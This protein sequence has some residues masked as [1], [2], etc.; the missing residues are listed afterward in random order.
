MEL[1]LVLRLVVLAKERHTQSEAKVESRQR[2]RLN[3]HKA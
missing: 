3:E 2:G 1:R